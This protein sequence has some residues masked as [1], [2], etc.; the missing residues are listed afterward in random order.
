[1]KGVLSMIRYSTSKDRECRLII[2]WCKEHKYIYRLEETSGKANTDVYP[3]SIL[4]P[5]YMES[6]LLEKLEELHFREA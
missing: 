1:M 2:R 6:E 5:S 3:F 4:A